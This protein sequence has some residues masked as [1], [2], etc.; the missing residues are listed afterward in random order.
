MSASSS[1]KGLTPPTSGRTTPKANVD[2]LVQDDPKTENQ[3][4]PLVDVAA[5]NFSA[6][7]E[8]EQV[9]E[10]SVKI[11]LSKSQASLGATV[12]CLF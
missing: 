9:G 10:E 11:R 2:E 12:G 5:V 8:V 1:E 7:R 3:F 4:T 6:T